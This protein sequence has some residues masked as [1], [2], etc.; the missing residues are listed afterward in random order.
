[1]TSVLTRGTWVAVAGALVLGA[2]TA[3]PAQAVAGAG[4]GAGGTAPAQRLTNLA[5]LDWLTDRVT[6]PDTAAHTTYRLTED[7]KIGVI[8]V[9]ADARDGGTFE[10]VGGGGL[11]PATGHWGQGS[12]DSDDMTRAAV[13]Y[14]RDWLATGSAHAKEQAYQQLRGVAYFQTA[15]GPYAG[16]GVLWMQPDGSLNPTPT[17]PDSPNPAD[18]GAS[19]WL[20]R[21][22]WAYGEGYAAFRD[23]DPDFAAFLAGRMRLTVAALDRDVLSN[24]GKY[25]VIHGIRVPAWLIVD[26]ADASSEAMLGLAAY[27]RA[28]GPGA[29]RAA[30]ALMKLARGVAEM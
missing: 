6:V 16:E 20:A 25:Q 13:V 21:T 10:R 15:T 27:V 7:P 22:L 8:W 23:S 26:G 12:Y 9:Y 19:Y 4:V 2:V 5:H 29:G 28:G 14:L 30:S 11:D 24:Y 3:T 1:M 17:P 18:S